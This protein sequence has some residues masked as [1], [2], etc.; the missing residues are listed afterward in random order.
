MKTLGL[1]G[2]LTWLSTIEYYRLINQGVNARLGASHSAKCVVFS[3]DFEPI[4]G[5][6]ASHDWDAFL[7]IA[8][9]VGQSLR[10]AGADA[11]VLCAN[12]AHAVAD[13]L[14]QRID[15]PVIHLVDALAAEIKH[16][17]LDNVALLGTRYTMEMDF[18]RDRLKKHGI[19][20]TVPG[21]ADRDFI[22]ASIFEEL[23]KEIFLPATKQRYQDIIGGLANGGAQGCVLG[24]TEIPLIIKQADSPVPVFDTTAIHAAAAVDFALSS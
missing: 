6:T 7:E 23:G 13:R 2:G 11:I 24:C 15:V 8:V 5:I 4:R 17:G 9:G 22:H 20:A 10:A 16:A 21:T 14:Q 12:T 18:F 3:V 19:I 1:M